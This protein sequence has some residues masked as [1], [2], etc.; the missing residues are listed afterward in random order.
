MAKRK[1]VVPI[2]RRA[3]LDVGN[4]IFAV[5]VVLLAIHIFRYFTKEHISFYEVTEKAVADDNICQG[6][7]LR[8]ETVMETK[9]GG[10]IS[11]YVGD[12]E[13]VAKNT[14]IYS[15]D[16]RGDIYELL[17]SE[18]TV[19]TLKKKDWNVIRSNIFSYVQDYSD[20]R[21]SR[22]IDF[23]YDIE[24]TMLELK[25]VNM[26]K[27]MKSI[28]KETGNK[29]S[30]EIVKSEQSGIISYCLDGMENV[31]SEDIT[32]AY[33]NKD[34]YTRTQLRSSQ[35]AASGSAIYK[36]VS[37][38]NWQIVV[39]L[40]EDQYEKTADKTHIDVT[41][42]KDG[43]EATAGIHAYKKEDRYYACLSLDKYMIQYLNDRYIEV[44]L[45]INSARG[46]KI[47]NSAITVRTL[48]KIPEEYYRTNQS[49][50]TGVFRD[51]YDDMGEKQTK[52]TAAIA[53]FREEGYVYIDENVLQSG[54]V[55]HA[56]G[57][58][59]TFVAAEITEIE[60]VYNVNNGYCIFERIA[61]IYQNADYTIVEKDKPDS[62]SAYDHIVLNAALVK[63]GDIVY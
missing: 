56:K 19:G 4:I 49:G 54:A 57:K 37:D 20:S 8:N 24:N 26:L 55:L 23:K 35:E 36:M 52:F 30:F 61:K 7:I 63:D 42:V 22:V 3:R 10:Y 48:Y 21:Y 17:A 47:P 43:L 34:N 11:Y 39:Q 5:I 62:I 40:T 9:T 38:D 15:V 29:A 16:E 60:G 1:K 32:D 58:K 28:L 53:V 33:F 6:I 2:Q 12:G 14:P 31:T 18:E 44:E 13:R 50:D 27:N 59:K 45:S 51:I 46:L 25:N 41:F